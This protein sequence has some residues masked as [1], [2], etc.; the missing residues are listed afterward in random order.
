[1]PGP[2]KDKCPLHRHD[3]VYLI[4]ILQEHCKV[5]GYVTLIYQK[6]YPRVGNISKDTGLARSCLAAEGPGAPSPDHVVPKPP[7][8][9][10]ARQKGSW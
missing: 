5:S 7:V 8:C 9:S 2:E 6:R 1:M 3:L 10:I 4:G